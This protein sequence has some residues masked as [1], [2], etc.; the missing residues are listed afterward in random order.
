MH[1]FDVCGVCQQQ[2]NLALG[3]KRKKS[4]FVGTQNAGGGSFTRAFSHC[5]FTVRL[6]VFIS[7]FDS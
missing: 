4:K 7:L 3:G 2:Q 5:D 6:C 1:T